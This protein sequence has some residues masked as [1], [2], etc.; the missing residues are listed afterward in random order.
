MSM[1]TSL[2][3]IVTFF[4][5]TKR[6]DLGVTTVERV[7]GWQGSQGGGEGGVKAANLGYI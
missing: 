3:A 1:G 4:G 5:V 6:F 7:G 2:L